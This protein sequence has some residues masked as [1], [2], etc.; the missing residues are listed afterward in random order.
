MTTDTVEVDFITPRHLA[1]GGD[2]AWI[3][4]PLH[5]ACGWSHGND[6]LMPR[7]LL[8]SPD[9]AAL[10]RLEPR[11]DRPWWTLRHAA[12]PDRPAWTATFGARTPVELIAAVTDALTDPASTHDSS[13][14]PYSSLRQAGWTRYFDDGLVSFDNTSYIER[15][16]PPAETGAWAV[17]TIAVGTRDGG[18]SAYFGAHTPRHLVAAFTAGLASPEP[19]LRTDS[20]RTPNHSVRETRRVPAADVAGALEDRIR[21]LASRY[22]APAVVPV[23]SRHSP[24]KYGRSR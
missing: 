18:W 20:G 15:L 12:A 24:P 1:S 21:S 5:R 8:A 14:D 17:T 3:T 4:I 11:P 16:A 9:Q 6:P 10:L 19:L 2:P 23:P 13:C 7:V 22:T